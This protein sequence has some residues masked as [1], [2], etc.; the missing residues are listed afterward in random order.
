MK[1]D[2]YYDSTVCFVAKSSQLL[3]R[4]KL[5]DHAQHF[6]LVLTISVGTLVRLA[7]FA[8]CGRLALQASQVSEVIESLSPL[9]KIKP[10]LG[11]ILCHIPRI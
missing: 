11:F 1:F 5:F 10:R 3:N 2:V 4:M 7:S 6:C 8:D 9:L